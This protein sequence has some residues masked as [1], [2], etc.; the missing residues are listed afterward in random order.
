MRD[1][2][3][4]AHIQWL[5]VLTGHARNTATYS[6]SDVQ[7]SYNLVS[8]HM[9]WMTPYDFEYTVGM[10]ARLLTRTEDLQG[11]ALGKGSATLGFGVGWLCCGQLN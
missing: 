1:G 2:N 3:A 4:E 9:T 8:T 6:E 10:C 7:T 5:G 11:V